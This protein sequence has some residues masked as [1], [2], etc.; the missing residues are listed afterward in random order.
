M[1]EEAVE[2][3]GACRT[4]GLRAH[5]FRE[6]VSWVATL[7]KLLDP[8]SKFSRLVQFLMKFLAS[9]GSWTATASTSSRHLVSSRTAQRIVDDGLKV[10]AAL[11]EWCFTA[12]QQ[13]RVRIN[14]EDPSH[15]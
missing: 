9:R 15:V 3:T 13:S 14:P 11:G 7:G 6:K 5:G 4:D 1:L 12:C 2:L 10:T 8:S